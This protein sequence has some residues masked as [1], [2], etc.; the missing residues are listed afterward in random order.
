MQALGDLAPRFRLVLGP[1]YSHASRLRL[2]LP[3]QRSRRA[4]LIS[5]VFLVVFSYPLLAMLDAT[6]GSYDGELFSLFSVL[7]TLFWSLGWSVGVLLLALVFLALS[8]GRETLEIRD[9]SVRL[10]VGL[11]GIG[12]GADYAIELIRNLETQSADESIGS[13]WRGD[14]LA[15]EFAGDRIGFGSAITA[16]RAN[17]ILT[18]MKTLLPAHADPLP[19]LD[20]PDLEASESQGQDESMVRKGAVQQETDSTV[21]PADHA[22]PRSKLSVIAL[23]IANLIP[24]LGVLIWDWRIG[25]IMLL[26]WA[27]SAVIGFYNLLKMQRVAGWAILFFGPFFVGHYGG[28]MVGH[29]LFIYGFFGENFLNNSDVSVAQ[30]LIDFQG[31]A[32]AL[33]GF[34]ISH[35]VSYYTNFLGRREYVGV[36]VAAQMGQPYRRIIIMHVTIIFGGFLVMAFSSVL[37]ALLLLIALKI[38]ADLR[39]HIAEHDR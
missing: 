12:F 30:L 5:G 35:G 10:L 6:T 11:P 34:A 15:F 26:Y 16:S 18:A 1:Q 31:L 33:I 28:F 3:F 36:E 23:M 32:P 39:G 20:L 14:H 38:G 4:I 2:K 17:E 21:L 9:D 24:L 37:P 7:F 19:E 8:F 22:K 27:E 29:L 25:D 13:A